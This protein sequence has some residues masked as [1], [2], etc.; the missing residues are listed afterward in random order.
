MGWTMDLAFQ[1]EMML[2]AQP[3]FSIHRYF[4]AKN[5]FL[6]DVKDNGEP[7]GYIMNRECAINGINPK[8]FIAHLVY[9]QSIFECRLDGDMVIYPTGKKKTLAYVL[10]TLCGV[11]GGRKS[12]FPQFYGLRKQIEL[13]CKIYRREYNYFVDGSKRKVRVHKY[14]GDPN[15]NY[16]KPKSGSALALFVFTPYNN[17]LRDHK[18]IYKNL[19]GPAPALSR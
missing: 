12:T 8:F 17:V 2:G 11:S 14:C 5:C 10:K 1:D 18:R 15:W 7:V 6:A 13:C 16:V 9:E 19:F 3:G 4:K